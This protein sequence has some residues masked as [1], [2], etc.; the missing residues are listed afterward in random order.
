MNAAARMFNQGALSRGWAV[1][2]FLAR[3]QFSTIVLVLA[4]LTSA[5]GIIYVANM[6]RGLNASWQQTLAERDH[7][8]VQWGQLLLEKGTRMRQARV[9][10]IASVRLGMVMPDSK[11]VVIVDTGSSN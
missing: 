6:A 10:R 11:S 4:I 8:H 5:L 3:T 7:M 1:S 2:L 9:Q